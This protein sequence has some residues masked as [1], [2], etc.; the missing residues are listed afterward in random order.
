MDTLEA[1]HIR[2]EDSGHQQAALPPW[3]R[4]LSSMEE[5]LAQMEFTG[6]SAQLHNTLE[7]AQITSPVPEA[8]ASQH[9]KLLNFLAAVSLTAAIT[10]YRFCEE[11]FRGFQ[12]I[13][14]LLSEWINDYGKS[15]PLDG[16]VLFSRWNRAL[17]ELQ[18][19][20]LPQT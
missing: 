9:R 11:D 18:P 17:H 12:Q 16:L 10:D 2:P 1:Q 8:F 7:A 5:Q 20:Q 6:L 4:S 15:F 19:R 3:Q 14:E 13:R